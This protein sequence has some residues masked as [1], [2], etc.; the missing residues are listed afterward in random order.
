MIGLRAIDLFAGAGGASLGLIAAGWDVVA[1]VEWDKDASET[2][3]RN[4]GDH[5]VEADVAG[6]VPDDLPDADYWHASPPCQGFSWAGKRDPD[7]PRNGLWAEV[8]RLAAAKRPAFL[9]IENVLGMSTTRMDRRIMHA[10][11]G[12]GY[13]AQRWVLNAADYGVPQV[14]RRILLVCSPPDRAPLVPPPTH[15][16]PDPLAKARGERQ[17]RGGP[18]TLPMV[19]GLVPWVT[20]AQAL[21]IGADR[22][23]ATVSHAGRTGSLRRP[24]LHPGSFVVEEVAGMD[25][26]MQSARHSGSPFYDGAATPARTITADSRTGRGFVEPA[27]GDGPRL[28]TGH[29]GG[30]ADQFG[31]DEP[32]W[33]FGERPPSW[34][35]T[36]HHRGNSRTYDGASRPARAVTEHAR[37]DH[38]FLLDEPSRALLPGAHGQPGFSERHVAGYVPDP[39]LDQPSVTIQS[40]NGGHDVAPDGSIRAAGERRRYRDAAGRLHDRPG[41]RATL[42]RLTVEECARLQDFPAGFAFAGSKTSQYRQAGNALPPGLARAVAAAVGRLMGERECS[43]G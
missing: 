20:V 35:M 37:S 7:D 42:R 36:D 41:E 4:V 25:L 15:Y 26:P 14:R 40:A 32:A 3:R 33:T 8:Y 1:A 18:V 21:G 38:G 28:T 43:I 39:I 11:E 19:E 24:E 17:V 30:Y 27:P 16:D 12:L 6:L 23:H 34:V 22:P 31:V 10:F 29:F 5:V 13:R 2:Y 9:T